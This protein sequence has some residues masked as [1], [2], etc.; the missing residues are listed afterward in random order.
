MF[1]KAN[2]KIDFDFYGLILFLLVMIPNFIWFR[3]SAPNDI[4]RGESI[5]PVIDSIASVFQVI[6]IAS[7]CIVTN[8]E[9]IRPMTKP[10]SVGIAAVVLFYFA[11]WIFYYQGTAG[12]FII[13]VLCIAPCVSFLLFSI[14]RKNMFAFI[15]A[16]IFLICHFLYGLINFIL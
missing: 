4:L 1:K 14:A 6:M 10:F 16:A 8:R 2:Y 12:A 7:L 3:V 15:S 13:L 9:C 5:T 11:G